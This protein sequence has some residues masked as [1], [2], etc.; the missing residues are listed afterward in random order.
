MLILF[1]NILFLAS[2]HNSMSKIQVEL[3]TLNYSFSNDVIL[4]G[5]C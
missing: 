3:C 2:I 1:L 4:K 5:Q